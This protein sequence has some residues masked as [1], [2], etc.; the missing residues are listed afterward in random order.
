MNQVRGTVDGIDNIMNAFDNFRGDIPYY[1]VWFTGKTKAFQYNGDDLDAGYELLE[2]TLKMFQQTGD[3]AIYY[4][5][6]HPVQL[7]AYKSSSDDLGAIP[8]RLNPLVEGASM[9]GLPR[10]NGGGSMMTAEMWE[11]HTMMKTLPTHIKTLSERLDEL[12]E[13]APPELDAIGRV[14]EVLNTPT[15]VKFIE[16][17]MPIIMGKIT[18]AQPPQ[19]VRSPMIAGPNDMVNATATAPAPN[20]PGPEYWERIDAILLR[21]SAHCQ[22]DADLELL[23]KLAETKPDIFKMVLLQLRSQV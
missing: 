19:P 20:Q 11:L 9:N 12:E 7:A 22:L 16:G 14:T 23:A 4:I 10:G 3:N 13:A 5:R 8:I 15:V 1:S 21:L 6:I 18:G 17:L 2:T